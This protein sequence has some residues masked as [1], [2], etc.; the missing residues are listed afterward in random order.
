[1]SY[2]KLTGHL[3]FAIVRQSPAFAA[4]PW[5]RSIY[6]S[7]PTDKEAV[8]LANR[9]KRNIGFATRTLRAEIPRFFR[10]GRFTWSMFADNVTFADDHL[11]TRLRITG[12]G[13]YQALSSFA[14]HWVWV[15]MADTPTVELLKM[16]ETTGDANATAH[17]L[18]VR[19]LFTGATRITRK[20]KTFEG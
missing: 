9:R 10:D 8:D 11:H 5:R 19:F 20:K 3:N 7:P 2:C 14:Y 1:M 4:F 15:F 13:R 12:K 17:R 18:N 16:E 6:T